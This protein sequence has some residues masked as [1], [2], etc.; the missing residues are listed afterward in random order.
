MDHMVALLLV[1]IILR[2]ES[3]K[4]IAAIYVRVPMFFTNVFYIL[5]TFSSN[6]ILVFIIT[7]VIH[8]ESTFVYGVS[9]LIHFFLTCSS[10]FPNTIY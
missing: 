3:K 9:V 2:D 7:S 5:P 10:P 1:F 4:D 8:L 6:S